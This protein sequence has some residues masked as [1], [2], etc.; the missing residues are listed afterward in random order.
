MCLPTCGNC[1]IK[2][3][4]TKNA[5]TA[6]LARTVGYVFQNPDHQIFADSLREEVAFG[7]KNL[8]FEESAIPA[9]VE[10]ALATVGLDKIDKEEHPLTLS[11]GD[12]QRLAIASVLAMTCDIFVID[13]PTRQ[14]FEEA[15]RS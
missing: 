10:E 5:T 11:K 4:N 7:L 1:F 2:G 12:R 14:D 6:D 3:R 9:H 13:E 8:G 15:G